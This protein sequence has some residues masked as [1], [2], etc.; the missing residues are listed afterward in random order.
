MRDGNEVLATGS[1]VQNGVTKEALAANFLAN[2]NGHNFVSS[3]SGTLVSTQGGL[4]SYVAS[5]PNG[6]T[7][8]VALKGV[9]NAYGATGNDTLI[10]DGNNN[11]LA[12][13]A[14]AAGRP[15]PLP[16]RHRLAA[17]SKGRV[18]RPPHRKRAEVV[19]MYSNLFASTP[20][21]ARLNG[22]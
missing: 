18:A 1:F 12:G 9:A 14:G 20:R 15:T 11:W 6:E 21:L 8:D 17:A 16:S 5:D 22:G 19:P 4:S 13:G 3:G 10:G 7:I 2:P